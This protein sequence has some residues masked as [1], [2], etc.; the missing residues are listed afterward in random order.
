MFPYKVYKLSANMLILCKKR[1]VGLFFF[2]GGEGAVVFKKMFLS[3]SRD[4]FGLPVIFIDV[5]FRSV[6][7]ILHAITS[8][9]KVLFF[10]MFAFSQRVLYIAIMDQ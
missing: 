1:A 9:L 5:G 6:G 2:C 10:P 7:S 4:D 8:V 3:M